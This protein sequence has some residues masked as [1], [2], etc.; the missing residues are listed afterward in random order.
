MLY[1]AT[2]GTEQ[3]DQGKMATDTQSENPREPSDQIKNEEVN[4][5]SES[6]KASEQSNQIDREEVDGFDSSGKANGQT[7]Q[8][9]EADGGPDIDPI[10]NTGEV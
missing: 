6:K 10:T 9:K 1:F 4:G 3:N 7:D 5:N 8:V 2:I